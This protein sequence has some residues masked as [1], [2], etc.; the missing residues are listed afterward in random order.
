[1]PQPAGGA[2]QSIGDAEPAPIAL[3]MSRLPSELPK[4]TGENKPLPNPSS[5]ATG[6]IATPR[7]DV[8]SPSTRA[9]SAS[10]PAVQIHDQIASHLDQVRQV[11]RVDLQ[12]DLHPPELGR[13]QLHLTLEDGRVN[14]HMTVQ[15][16]NAKRLIDQQVEPLRVRFADMGVNVGQFDVRR[17]GNSANPEQQH[18]A[19]RS[20]QASQADSATAPRLQKTYAKVANASALVDV[21]A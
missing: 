19:E 15:D 5:S 2:E 16:D 11:G 13:V 1:M 20:A 21:I 9:A 18:A 8:S 12:F 7:P 6:I 10:T 4:G 14:V 17:D 3:K